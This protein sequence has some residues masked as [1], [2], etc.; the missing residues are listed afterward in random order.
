MRNAHRSVRARRYRLDRREIDSGRDDV[1]LGDPAGRVVG[2]DDLSVGQAAVGELV[3]GLAADVRADEVEH[4]LL[5]GC[6]QDR[7]LD[8]LRDE[9]QPE[10]E[11][12]DVGARQQLCER[13]K[14]HG[15]PTPGG[16]ARQV[17]VLV[18]LRVGRLGVEDDEPRVDPFSA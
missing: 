13:A 1:G 5:A 7:E 2:T 12:E 6:F 4:G 10:V 16:P 8:S 3:G 15:L 14:L 9:S 17:E 11:V 18:G